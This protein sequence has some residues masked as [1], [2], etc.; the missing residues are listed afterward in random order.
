MKLKFCNCRACKRGRH[1][2]RN[3]AD[4][5]QTVRKGRAQ[6]KGKLKKG[7]YDTIPIAI[8]AGYTD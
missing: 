1:K 3:Q 4:I 2:K 6:V 7:D 5:K 8:C